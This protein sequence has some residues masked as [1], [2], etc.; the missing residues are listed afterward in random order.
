[1]NC[2]VRLDD[3]TAAVDTA[4]AHAGG[5]A[6]DAPS[7]SR[8][9]GFDVN[10]HGHV[11]CIELLLCQICDVVELSAPSTRSILRTELSGLIDGLHSDEASEETLIELRSGARKALRRM[12]PERA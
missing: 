9:Q 3:R 7:A 8:S 12:L 1:M 11:L 6:S 2:D 4:R 10:L 5:V